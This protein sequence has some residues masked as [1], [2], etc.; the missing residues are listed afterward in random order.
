M[1]EK[2]SVIVPVYNVEKYI[3]ECIKSIINQD[4]E[5]IEIILVDDGSNDKSGEICDE[6]TLKDKR[7]KV[8]HKENGGVSSAR[9][10]G[11]ESSTG[12]YIAFVDGDDYVTKDYVSYLF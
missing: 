6:Y 8:I 7:V 11:I 2:I 3:G 4:Y 1:N 5:N 12:E 9:N 10:R